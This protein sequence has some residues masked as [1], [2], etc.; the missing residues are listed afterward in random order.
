MQQATKRTSLVH[1]LATIVSEYLGVGQTPVWSTPIDMPLVDKRFLVHVPAP[2][3]KIK[4]WANRHIPSER[5]VKKW[6]QLYNGFNSNGDPCSDTVEQLLS[7]PSFPWQYCLDNETLYPLFDAFMNTTGLPVCLKYAPWKVVYNTLDRCTPHSYNYLSEYTRFNVSEISKE[8]GLQVHDYLVK[9][10]FNPDDSCLAAALSH[11]STT[12]RDVQK[13]VNVANYFQAEV[14]RNPNLS[15]S[16]LKRL[17]IDKWYMGHGVTLKDFELFSAEEKVLGYLR[18]TAPK[19]ARAST[20]QWESFLFPLQ[21]LLG[22]SFALNPN[23]PLEFAETHASEL[24]PY[25]SQNPGLADQYIQRRV[26]AE[27]ETVFSLVFY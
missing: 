22:D 26:L 5:L 25:L 4:N 10:G 2:P 6:E 19:Y 7:N 20:M 3:I 21:C 11:P 27:I 24:G 17:N 18:V 16:F 15:L 1:I 9:S 23:L 13:H 12:E 14:I 8:R